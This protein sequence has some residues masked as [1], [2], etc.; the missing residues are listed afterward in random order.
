MVDE[1][2]H[3]IDLIARR[4]WDTYDHFGEEQTL[5]E[6]RY[7]ILKKMRLITSKIR[8]ERMLQEYETL[9]LICC[10]NAKDIDLR[11]ANQLCRTFYKNI[12]LCFFG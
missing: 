1:K 11:F 5:I 6:K 7:K 8:E 4:I 12:N 3:D 9:T 10:K 2:E